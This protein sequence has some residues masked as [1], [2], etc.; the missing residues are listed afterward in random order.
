MMIENGEA[1]D[2]PEGEPLAIRSFESVWDAI[3]DTPEDAAVMKLR[4]ALLM[5]L[6]EEV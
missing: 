4:S 5:V 2:A 1:T 6:Q 3:E